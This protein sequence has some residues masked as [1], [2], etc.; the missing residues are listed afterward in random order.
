MQ[1]NLNARLGKQ[2]VL[3][4]AG[5]MPASFQRDYPS[6]PFVVQLAA[7]GNVNNLQISRISAE[8]PGALSL[9]GSG[10]VQQITDSIHRSA[11][12][13]L[14][15]RTQRLDFLLSLAGIPRDGSI[16]IPPLSM[17]AGVKMNGSQLAA[18]LLARE[19][20][21]R[22]TLNGTYNLASEAYKA[23]VKIDS[24][25]VNHFLPRDSIYSL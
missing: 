25:Q 18:N 22:L 3:L 7:D 2:D 10:H 17:N 24:L 9:T 1:A 12:I 8:L 4:L 6:R 14:Q 5:D 23:D 20:V 11:D 13:D 16:A 15:L 21:G 19:G